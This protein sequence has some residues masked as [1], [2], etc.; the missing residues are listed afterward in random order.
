MWLLTTAATAV[1]ATICWRLF[2][3]KYQLGFLTLMLWGATVMILVDHIIG[4]QGGEFLERTTDG[5]VHSGT[6][7]GLVML[8]PVLFIWALALIINRI[9][10]KACPERRE[11]DSSAS[12]E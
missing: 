1:L 4:Y 5:M 6:L 3:G 7:L 2:K 11:R 12:S 8:L 9:K 10:S